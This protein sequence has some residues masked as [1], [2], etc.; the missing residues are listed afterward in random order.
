MVHLQFGGVPVEVTYAKVKDQYVLPDVDPV[1]NPYL[2][3]TDE[4][5]VLRF[6]PNQPRQP[7]Q[8][9]LSACVLCNCHS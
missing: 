5:S 6:G 4:Q 3:E 7:A 9:S 8:I 2:I 1:K